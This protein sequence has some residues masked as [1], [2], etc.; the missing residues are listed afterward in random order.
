MIS[1]IFCCNCRKSRS[2]SDES[3][4][5]RI[6]GAAAAILTEHDSARKKSI[7]IPI[8]RTR[9]IGVGI[10]IE[11][12]AGRSTCMSSRPVG[13]IPCTTNDDRLCFLSFGDLIPDK[14]NKHRTREQG[15][16]NRYLP[17][18]VTDQRCGLIK[19]TV[20]QGL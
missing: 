19:L 16:G 17:S 18:V 14:F 8:P 1:E 4:S 12:N 3:H 2:K 6:A 11:K 5:V 10:G 13:C 9:Q 7:P 20:S 15:D